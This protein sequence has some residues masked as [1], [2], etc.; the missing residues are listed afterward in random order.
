MNDSIRDG[1]TRASS[2]VSRIFA[3]PLILLALG[4]AAVFLSVVAASAISVWII[5]GLGRGN[6]TEIASA[7]IAALFSIGFYAAFVRILER[8]SLRDFERTGA[9]SEWA[10]G[11][12]IGAGAMA[13]SIGAIAAFGGYVITGINPWSAMLPMVAIAILSGTV[14]EV[15]FRG[16]IFRF[17]EQWLG[18]WAALVAS[19]AFFGLAHISNPNASPLAACAIAIEAGLLLGAVYMVTRRLWAVIGLHMAWNFTQGGIFGVAVSGFES[20]GLINAKISGSDALTGGAFGAE[21]S[22]PAII[23][24]TCIGFYFLLQARRKGHFIQPSW[25]RFK[26]GSETP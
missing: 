11:A 24:C 19:A 18:S 26:T 6:A 10:W 15:L 1:E 7:I 23:I 20:K 4:V 25:A 8:K 9:A 17:V 5:H 13:L 3:H 22:W 2:L 16:V 12:G 21:A 14:E